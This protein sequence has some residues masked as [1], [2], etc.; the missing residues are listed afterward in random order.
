M[1]ALAV[2]AG[3][4]VAEESTAEQRQQVRLPETPYDY[5]QASLPKYVRKHAA[6]YDNTPADN[7]ITNHGATLGRVLFYDRQL[8]RN[9]TT[10]CASCHQ[11]KLAFTDGKK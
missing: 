5:T 10:S 8:S 4:A 7:P 11:Q 1:V 2:G 3:N 6:M 9:G